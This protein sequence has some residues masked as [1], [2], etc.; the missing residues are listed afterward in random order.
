MLLERCKRKK[1]KRERKKKKEML[2]EPLA[3]ITATAL[4]VSWPGC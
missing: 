1:R 2:G 4:L 3:E